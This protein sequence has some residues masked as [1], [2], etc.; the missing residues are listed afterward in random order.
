MPYINIFDKN[1]YYEIYGEDKQDTLVYLHGGPGASCL[2]YVN[3]AKSLGKELKVIIFDQLG[4]L[5]SD[6]IQENE[7]YSM[8]I[9][10]KMIEEMRKK[11]AVNKWSVI[12][13]SYGGLLAVFYAY[14]YPESVDKIILDCPSL[15]FA[16]SAKSIACYL[17]DYIYKSHND[18]AV[19]LCE[20]IKRTEYKD[21]RVIFDIL[22]L[23]DYVKDM[24]LRN[25]LHNITFDEYAKSLCAE[26]ITEDIWARGEQH[27]MK[28]IDDGKMFE[29]FLPMLKAVNKPI[30]LLNG[31]YDPSCSKNQ[32][33]YIL[34]NVNEIKQVVFENSGHFPRIEE[35]EKYTDYVL[36]FIN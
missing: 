18:D 2:D 17:T 19:I 24:Q 33:D 11:L 4:V 16:D 10:V 20:K 23:L 7:E 22:T 32:I 26:G 12:G 15:Y 28:L 8:D 29:N 30:L 5:R 25:Y 1:I 14:T 21:K 27:L 35:A 3:Q 36:N 34:K 6:E 13:H 31:K 9:Q